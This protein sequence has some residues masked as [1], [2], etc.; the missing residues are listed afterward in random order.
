VL[1]GRGDGGFRERL[2][3]PTAPVPVNAVVADVD[4]DGDQ[5]DGYRR[6]DPVIRA[7]TTSSVR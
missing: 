6:R 2:A 4:G 3:F 7:M 5:D 1:L